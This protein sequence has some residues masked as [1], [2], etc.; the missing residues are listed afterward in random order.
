MADEVRAEESPLILGRARELARIDEMVERLVAGR[1]GVV[2][3]LGPPGIGL[4]TLLT[5]ALARVGETVG[6]V[7]SVHVPSGL[8]EGEV[9][10]AVA[11]SVL[12]SEAYRDL[13][14][15]VVEAVEL[16]GAVSPDDPRLV[17]AAVAGMRRLSRDRPLC[18][19]VDNLPVVDESV[20]PALASLAAGLADVPALALVTSHELPPSSFEESP[21]GPLW[22]HRVPALLMP[23]AVAL[24][25]ATA[26]RWVPHPVA[27]AVALR[28]GMN[29]GD[30]VAV[31]ESLDPDQLA[32]HE[33]LPE[34]LPGTPVSAATYRS[35]WAGLGAPQRLLVLGTA[36]AV[37]PERSTLEEC[38]GA[39]LRD[40]VGPG[41][42]PVL[43]EERGLVRSGDPRLLSAVRALTPSHELRAALGAL[44]ACHPEDALDR[45]WLALRGGEP[46]TPETVAALLG[47]ARDHLDRGE[48]EAV[49]TL[50]DD[51]VQHSG[52]PAPPPEL[53]VLGGVAATYCGHPARAVT[54]LTAA[55]AEA[56]DDLG[57]LVPPLLVATTHRENGVPHRLVT[58]CLRR[59]EQ[60]E[61]EAAAPIAALAARL[62]AEYGQ[63]E[64]ARQYLREAER[65]HQAG[66]A[67]EDR[68]PGLALARAMVDRSA[69]RSADPLT[70]FGA[71]RPGSDVVGWLCEVGE[72]EQLV[73]RGTWVQARGAVADL[74]ALVRR[75]PVPVLRAQLALATIR[76]H[77][78]AGEYRRADE[79]AALAV[80]QML[81]LHVPRGGAGIALLAQVAL[82]RGRTAEA[83]AW[84]ADLGE[85][86]QVGSGAPAVT[87]A[88]HET[89][90]FRARLAGDAATAA[91]H[92]LRALRE[93]LVQSSTVLDLV[94]LRWRTGV[95]EDEQAAFLDAHDGGSDTAIGAALA[96]VRAPAEHVAATLDRVSQG[97]HVPPA[98]EAQL[99]E[100][101]ADLLPEE[102]QRVAL[103]RRARDLYGRT[104]A[105]GRADAAEREIARLERSATRGDLGSLT[106]DER[107]IARLV[108][109]GATNKEVAAALYLSVRTVE[110][111]L[112][113][114]YRKLGIGT[115]RELRQM[116]GLA[117]S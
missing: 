105:V 80:A 8:L 66:S 29:P 19:T 54:L 51:V 114:I 46:P 38:A 86:A 41:G 67:G 6:D 43:S 22:V 60:A 33:P 59:L 81:P 61:P 21:V 53:L 84:L 20:L 73:E 36:A 35:W 74:Q 48:A 2:A 27:A 52:A 108:H 101:A 115:R 82:V 24:V 39:V 112:T 31:C 83:E 5:E 14:D 57:R 91:E 65:L 90:G 10:A 49:E 18:V 11:A 1:G 72:L 76:L 13:A 25:R 93:G 45:H 75:F 37:R 102:G 78:A 111:R 64:E 117:E 85:L 44:S 40:V 12:T 94:H 58:A 89:L 9:P 3:L 95:G 62:C 109:G 68:D 116:P 26:D 97:A 99:L 15:V 100:L 70:A 110:L 71:P 98:H 77:L 28:C 23:D 17:R 32:G 4:T 42:E 7:R 103:L 34:V 69:P 63:S 96:L 88:L 107:T 56:P 92:Y 16:G 55:L 106:A 87:A 104:G 30:L 113:S 47:G 79:A 50:V